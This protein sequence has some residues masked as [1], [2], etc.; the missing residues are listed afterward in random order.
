[1]N[2]MRYQSGRYIST[3]E[4]VWRILSF[5][6]NERFPPVSHLENGQRVYFDHD[7][8]REMV[9]NPRSTT[10]NGVIET[11]SGRQFR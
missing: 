8:I 10:L 2:M 9:E 5:P 3:S 7:N 11:L 6:I 4:A 1:M